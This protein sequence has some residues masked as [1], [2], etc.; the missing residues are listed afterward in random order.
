MTHS[1]QYKGHL[2]EKAEIRGN[3]LPDEV[4]DSEISILKSYFRDAA[5]KLIL[6]KGIYN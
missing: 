4:V 3:T 5:W 2:V 1:Q 6:E